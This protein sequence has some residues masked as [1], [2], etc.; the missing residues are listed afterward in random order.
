[1]IHLRAP[2]PDIYSHEDVLATFR[3]IH[4]ALSRAPLWLLLQGPR[5]R[6]WVRRLAERYRP[7]TWAPSALDVIVQS[8]ERSIVPGAVDTGLRKFVVRYARQPEF[9]NDCD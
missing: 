2:A 6:A 7:Y 8:T 4:Y 5:R 3:R 1:M 9:V